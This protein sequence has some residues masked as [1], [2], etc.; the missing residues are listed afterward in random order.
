MGQAEERHRGD[1]EQAKREQDTALAQAR[2]Q[3]A[4]DKAESLAQHEANLRQE[5]ESKLAA[6]QAS[7]RDEVA[8]R[9]GEA[10]EEAER[11]EQAALDAVRS[12]DARRI[13]EIEAERDARFA[14]MEA[15]SA[16]ERR[17]AEGKF[18][19][20]EM[21]LAATRGEL[22]A[23]RETKLASDA[24]AE[25]KLL[26]LGN[27]LGEAATVRETLERNLGEAAQRVESLEGDLSGTR[28]ELGDTQQKLGAETS[29]A[30]RFAS[31]WEM[32]KQ[33]LERAKDA[34]AVALAQIEE[35]EAR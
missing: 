24:A 3:A 20:V 5:Q 7:H 32:D 6:L 22:E 2:D 29:R 1:L 11:K 14:S 18:A 8:N 23:L 25:L 10:H 21:D 31:K 27:R 34:L 17:E 16:D 4:H 9:L 15:R 28:A 26:D 13:A 33:S 19:R 30:D 35:A 12:E